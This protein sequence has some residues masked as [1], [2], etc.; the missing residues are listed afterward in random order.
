[1]IPFAFYIGI[2][3]ISRLIKA[4]P[5][6]M[7]L[8]VILIRWGM[9]LAVINLIR[10]LLD[11]NNKVL[12]YMAKASYPIYLFHHPVIIALGYFYVKNP[13][14]DSTIP[15]FFFLLIVSLIITY[16]LYELL[17]NRNRIGSFLFTGTP[18]NE[19]H[20]K[21]GKKE[22]KSTVIVGETSPVT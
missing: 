10:L 15:G 22:K 14:F 16:S 8:T 1:L 21:P 5:L 2:L 11:F 3:V 17:I 20:D 7:Q 9:F 13:V 4:D 6:V 19:K 18:L 12:G